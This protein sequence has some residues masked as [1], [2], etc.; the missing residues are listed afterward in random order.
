MEIVIVGILIFIGT[1]AWTK[2]RAFQRST[3]LA[4][5]D[6]LINRGR[7]YR[8]LNAY[9]E[10]L[11]E[12]TDSPLGLRMSHFLVFGADMAR[13]MAG[14]EPSTDEM[15]AGAESAAVVLTVQQG[16]HALLMLESKQLG[17]PT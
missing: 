7:L 11:E 5:M 10:R 16:I 4:Q 9:M 17:K 15:D 8:S 13:R 2:L 6:D 14:I 1:V 3:A 12:K